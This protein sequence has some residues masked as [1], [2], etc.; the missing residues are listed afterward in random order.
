MPKTC[1]TCKLEKS[2]TEFAIRND[3][4][5]GL[6]ARCKV[7][8]KL[9]AQEN[10]K[11]RSEQKQQDNPRPSKLINQPGYWVAR[12]KFKICKKHGVS[13]VWYLAQHKFQ[14]YKCAICRDSNKSTKSSFHIDHDHSTGEA[15]A[16]LC[17]RCNAAVGSRPDQ[18]LVL[19]KA[20]NYLREHIELRRRRSTE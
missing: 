10:Y 1:T 9:W 2:V 14:D 13:L 19:H 6:A 18:S 8:A 7:C 16:L 20:I 15:R 12:E 3:R 11:K 17:A 4:K 5:V